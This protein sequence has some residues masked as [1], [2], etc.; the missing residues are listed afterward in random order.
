[1]ANK[2]KYPVGSHP[3]INKVVIELFSAELDWMELY[4]PHTH[5]HK[6]LTVMYVEGF[7][8][9]NSIMQLKR[10]YFDLKK[11]KP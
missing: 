11:K 10:N 6:L 5:Q 7:S 9:L 8:N 3:V 2:V 1:M 4:I